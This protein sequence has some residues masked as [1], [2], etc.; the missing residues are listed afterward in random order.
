MVGAAVVVLIG[1]LFAFTN[2][3]VIFTNL[4][5]TGVPVTTGVVLV[6]V[7]VNDVENL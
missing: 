1:L 7:V 3:G 4:F 6:V 2:A 5:F